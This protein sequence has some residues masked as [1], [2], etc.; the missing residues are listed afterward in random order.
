MKKLLIILLLVFTM[1]PLLPQKKL[2]VLK[3]EVAWSKSRNSA[4]SKFIPSTVPGAVQLDIAKA[5]KYGPYSYAENWKDYLWMEDQFYT[6][7]TSFPKPELVLGE[8][9]FFNSGGIDYQFEIYLNEEKIFEQ[10]GMF[11]PVK[12]DLTDKLKPKNELIVI[13]FPVPKRAPSPVD[14]SQAAHVVKPAV[15]YGWDWHPRLVPLGIWDETA[16][17]IQPASFIEDAKIQYELTP[18]MDAARLAVHFGGRNLKNANYSWKLTDEQGV[19]VSGANGR[20]E[21]DEYSG[22]SIVK[23]PELWWPHDHGKP[24]LYNFLL[25]LSNNNG[26]VQIITRKVGFRKVQLVMNEGAWNE[27]QGF[28]KTRSVP[29]AQFVVNGRRIFVKG[30]N[31]V[32][33]EIFPGVITADRYNKLLDLALKANFNILRVWGGGIVNKESF[34]DLCD[35]KG[36]LVWQE[37]PLACNRYPDDP[38]YLKILEQEATSII[39]RLADHPSLALWSGGNEL[40]NSWSGMDDQ[41]LPLRLLNSLTFGLSP[42]IPFI[43]TSPL[44]GMGHGNYV[45]RD[46]FTKEEVYSNMN[47]S[48]FTAYT[49]FGMPGPSSVELLKTIIPENELWPPRPGTSWESHHAFNAW[50]G[51]TWLVDDM[52]KDY[53]GP[54]ETLEEL[55][56][57]GQLL[58]SEGYKAIFEEARRQKPYCSMALNWCY[59]EPWPTAANNSLINYPDIPKPAFYAVS[60]SCR[61]LC[62]SARLRKFEW[63]TGE[64]FTADLWILND[65]PVPVES[66][67]VIVK[68]VSGNNIL[69]LMKWEFN[70]IPANTNLAGPTVRL[71]IPPM[72]ESLFKL[73]LEYSEHA[74]YNSEYF[75]VLK[76]NIKKKKGTAV[77]NQ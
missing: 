35:E 64:E 13:V 27:P 34:Y 17:E 31:W 2:P 70:S 38:H 39:K 72:D 25:E 41:S 26:V 76:E 14:R 24:Y 65:L 5:E 46:L 16:L 3:W 36:L 1:H 6:Y 47:R 32:N 67:K 71:K 9:L 57:Q 45:F 49:E 74:E 42:Q 18:A 20:F 69:E 53:F 59:N 33:P 10:E 58:Q 51:N 75:L 56:R 54:A 7:R 43:A 37:F 63:K 19:E 68:L 61:P 8:R 66:G 11:T 4:P 30:T 40:F 52:L 73:V 48:H 29:P 28:P 15:S 62:A 22:E 44:M 23:N 60:N 50:V 12:L 55:V 77:M 21:S